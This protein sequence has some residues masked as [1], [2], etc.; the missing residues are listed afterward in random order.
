[1]LGE[2]N[3]R[4]N[5]LS[6]KSEDEMKQQLKQLSEIKQR[7]VHW[8]VREAIRQYVERE[9]EEEV[10]RKQTINRWHAIEQ[11]ETVS[12]EAVMGWLDTWGGSED[13]DPPA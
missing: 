2:C 3:E 8:M 11:G 12:H 9:M 7:S 5:P 4:K 10:L 6:V 13:V 1:L